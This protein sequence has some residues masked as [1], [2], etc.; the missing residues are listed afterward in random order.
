M[1]L[2]TVKS[3]LMRGRAHLKERLAGFAQA[4]A[5]RPSSTF[6]PAE[7]LNMGVKGAK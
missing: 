3:R 7:A 1:H 5:K 6:Q 4:S 2:G